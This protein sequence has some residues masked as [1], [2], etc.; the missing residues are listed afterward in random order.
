MRRVPSFLS[1]LDQAAQ[2]RSERRVLRTQASEDAAMRRVEGAQ[3][4]W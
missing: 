4:I 2:G 3:V 1:V